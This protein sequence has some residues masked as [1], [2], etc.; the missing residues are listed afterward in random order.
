MALRNGS[1]TKDS[2][3]IGIFD[4]NDVYQ[5]SFVFLEI[6]QR[7]RL[8]ACIL[9]ILTVLI[10]QTGYGNHELRSKDCELGKEK[11]KE[12]LKSNSLGLYFF[13]LPDSKYNMT[14][15]IITEKLKVSVKGSGDIVTEE[16]T[17]YNE[18]MENEIKKVYGEDVF[19]RIDATIDSLYTLGKGDREVSYVGGS[20]AIRNFIFCNL[21]YFDV[22]PA[23]RQK[24]SVYVDV[25][26]SDKGRI[27]RTTVI[28]GSSK[29]FDD[30]A[31]RVVSL[32]KEWIPAVESSVP[33]KSRMTLR[34]LFDP[35]KRDELKCK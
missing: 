15:K 34:V 27:E 5:K 12:D 1:T 8:A 30:E 3:F 26:I 4:N 33:T 6:V 19:K 20:D 10:Y 13:G 22:K 23:T 2:S 24:P 18:V 25:I 29:K 7:M 28:K 14:V 21:N 35:T 16:G 11:A 9:T 17:C 31:I 32:L